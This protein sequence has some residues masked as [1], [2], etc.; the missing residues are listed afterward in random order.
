MDD[1]D[2][3]GE[4]EGVVMFVDVDV[5]CDRGEEASDT[6]AVLE[7]IV[8]VLWF[9]DAGGVGRKFCGTVCGEGA[10]LSESK[11]GFRGGVGREKLTGRATADDGGR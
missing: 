5:A 4:C 8:L 10:S 6:V 11:V 9:G 7:D 1:I 2:A 3:E